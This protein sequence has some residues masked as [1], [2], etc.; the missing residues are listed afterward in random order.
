MT[1]YVHHRMTKPGMVLTLLQYVAILCGLFQLAFL[2]DTV[3]IQCTA[4]AVFVSWMTLQYLKISRCFDDY[5]ISSLALFGL[6]VTSVLTSLI[7]QTLY[8]TPISNYLRSAVLTYGVLTSVIFTTIGMHWVYR[9]LAFTNAIRDWQ[10]E[11]IFTRLRVIEAPPARILWILGAIGALALVKGRSETGDTGGKFTQALWVFAWMPYLIPF[12]L[13]K[14]GEAYCRARGIWPALV[15]YTMGLM[16]IGMSMNTRTLMVAGPVT[17][18]IMFFIYTMQDHVPASRRQLSRALFLAV[19]FLAAVLIFSQISTAMLVVRGDRDHVEPLKL[20]KETFIVL[21]Q[22][23]HKMDMLRDS[24]YVNYERGFYNEVYIP[25]SVLAR[26]SDTKFADNVLSV[27]QEMDDRGRNDVWQ[28][29]KDHLVALIPQNWLDALGVKFDKDNYYY[30]GGDIYRFLDSGGEL[31]SFLTGSIWADLLALTGPWFLFAVAGINLVSFI[32]LDSLSKRGGGITKISPII[33]CMGWS[34]ILFG[35][36]G[37]SLAA[38][39]QFWL[40]GLPQAIVLYMT[41]YFSL[42][43]LLNTFFPAQNNKILRETPTWI[44]WLDRSRGLAYRYLPWFKRN[45]LH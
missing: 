27:A 22:E 6:L 39:I 11:H 9:K 19:S 42:R 26:F 5:P 35:L 37:E 13:R 34:V 30:S 8:L 23:R 2:F 38:R 36:S 18:G 17:A 21:V 7:S 32:A 16:L 4:L 44:H 3:N 15:L 33:V 41:A 31:G 29:T 20:I 40:R 28:F 1:S 25:N 24:A 12:Y 45:K 14:I 10:A 43:L